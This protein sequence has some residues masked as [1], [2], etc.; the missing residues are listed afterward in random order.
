MSEFKAG[1]YEVSKSKAGTSLCLYFRS[2][3]YY[4]AKCRVTANGKQY[5]DWADAN[6]P[7]GTGLP[8]RWLAQYKLLNFAPAGDWWDNPRTAEKYEPKN[9]G[10]FSRAAR[11]PSAREF[12]Q[13]AGTVN[14]GEASGL[15]CSKEIHVGIFFDG[16]NNNMNRDRSSMGHSNVVTLYDAHKDDKKEFFKYYIPGV[17][18]QFSE[19]GEDAESNS[20]GNTFAQGGEARI[21][22]GM[23][24]VFN[25]VCRAAT[26][27]DVLTPAEMK[28]YVTSTFDGLHTLWRLGDSKMQ[29]FFRAL[30]ARLLKAVEGKRPKITKVNVSV[31]GFSRGS[32]QARTFSQWIQKSTN[33]SVGGAVFSLHFL[34]IFDTVA[35]VMLADSSP[36]G[37]SGF[38][39]WA[40]GTMGI[41]GVLHTAH[42]VAAHEI[43]R[44]FPLSTARV[45]GTWPTGVREFVYPGAHSD[46]GGGYS[47]GEQGKAVSGRSALQSQI[48]LND[49][50]FEALN[51]GVKLRTK[52]E[53]PGEVK[54]DFLIDLALDKSFST[55]ANWTTKY[56]EKQNIAAVGGAPENH[57]HYHTQL[58]WR[59]R[60]SVSADSKFKALN[61]YSNSN[62]QDKTDLWEAELDWRR[63][64][65]AAQIAAI[66]KQD[67]VATRFGPK[68]VGEKRSHASVLQ[69]EI[70]HQVVAAAE[71]PADVSE[72]F[73]K[74]IH[75]SHAGFWLLGPRTKLEKQELLQEIKDKKAAQERWLKLANETENPGRK[76]NLLNNA[77]FY[78]LNSFEKRVLEA[79]AASPGSMPVFTDADAAELRRRGGTLTTATMWGMGTA[80]R[81]E[82]SGH[83]RYRRIF[84]Q[85]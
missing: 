28:H 85:S 69:Q 27:S 82:A 47:P 75:D 35:S 71:V 64:V 65:E 23:L 46:V 80:T 2:T 59:W 44:S 33:G 61:S 37:G 3:D 9:P 81:R 12:S 36:V 6:G 38:M 58:Y 83:G 11:K 17:G 19:I 77:R 39:D 15:C 5:L 51:V 10:A 73:D 45:G 16:T 4:T 8:G 22:Y 1:W 55:Y 24:Q 60:A 42:F 49:M 63:D 32:A 84:D 41:G 76:N 13:R 72:F 78:E 74:F 25:A 31:V 56:D 70:L 57:M 79:D 30:N 7:T 62:G 26:G 21:H 66:P 18:T 48:P 40:D 68:P 34:G 53:L 43:R 29:D 67:Y 20:Y 52:S 14:A 50:Y 54:A